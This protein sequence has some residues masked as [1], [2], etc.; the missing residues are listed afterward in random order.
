MCLGSVLFYLFL[1]FLV[2]VLGKV[3]FLCQG[4]FSYGSGSYAYFGV[5]GLSEDERR[6]AGWVVLH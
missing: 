2:P 1:Y 4:N 6:A 3:V 5:V